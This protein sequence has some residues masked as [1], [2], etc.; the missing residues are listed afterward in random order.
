MFWKYPAMGSGFPYPVPWSKIPENIL[1]NLRFISAIT[2]TL[3]IREKKAFLKSR[4]LTDPIN[5]LRI[6]RPDVPWLSQTMPGASVPVDVVPE[7]VTCAGPMTLSPGTVAEQDEGLASWLTG[8]PT[9]L[10]NLGSGFKFSEVHAVTMAQALA[11]IL[12][13]ANVQ[14]LWKIRKD[15]SYGDQYLEPLVP[16]ANKGRVRVEQAPDA[17]TKLS[18]KVTHVLW[19]TPTNKA[20]KVYL[21][22]FARLSED[23]GVGV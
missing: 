19:A 6:Y 1:L 22:N 14:I 8:A 11:E 15:V 17:I 21:Y 5:F 13:D 23:I 3:E 16:F 12:R 2:W 4:G 18:G 9:V 20:A 10:I 7:N